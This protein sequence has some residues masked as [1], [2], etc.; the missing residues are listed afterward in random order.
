MSWARF[1]T[2]FM[3]E[4][5]RTLGRPAARVLLVIVLLLAYGLTSGNVMVASGDG[6]VGG[7][8][9]WLTSEFQVAMFLSVFLPV[10]YLFFVSIAAGMAVPE[11]EELNVG[12]LLHATPL[13]VSEYLLGKYLAVVVGFALIILAQVFFMMVCNHLIPHFD[14]A[15]YFGPFSWRNYLRPFCFFTLPSLVGVAGVVFFLGTATR[16]PILVY[17]F[18]VALALGSIF[19]LIGWSPSWLPPRINQLL[20]VLDPSGFRWL[21]ETWFKVDRGVGHYNE[22]AV[23]FDGVFWLNRGLW[24]MVGVGA[25]ALSCRL[26]RRHLRAV[27]VVRGAAAAPAATRTETLPLTP[28]PV[29]PPGFLAGTVAVARFEA[30][31][32]L[33]HPGLY[34]FV[35]LILAQGGVNLWFKQGF[36]DMPVLLTPG[37]IA[38]GMWNLLTVAVALLLLFYTVE[39]FERERTTGLAPLFASTALPT[40]AILCG[41]V[42]ANGIVGVVV[43]I[44]A[45]ALAWVLLLVQGTIPMNILPFALVWGLVLLPTFLVWVAYVLFWQALLRSRYATYAVALATLVLFGYGQFTDKLTWVSNWMLWSS[46]RWSDLGLFELDRG[47]LLLNRLMVLGLALFLV[48]VALRWYPRRERDWTQLAHRFRWQPILWESLKLAPLAALP[49]VLGMVLWYQVETGREGSAVKKAYK[50]YWRQNLNTWKDVPIPALTAVEVNLR[51]EPEQQAFQVA[52]SY[53][54]RNDGKEP[55]RRL[56][57]TVGSHWQDLTWTLNGQAA[58][59]ENFAGLQVFQLNPPLAVGAA[60]RVGFGYHGQYP[61]GASK[62]KMQAGEFILPSGVVLNSF[63]ASF[64]PIVGYVESVGIDEENQYEP[65]QYDDDFHLKELAPLFGSPTPFTLKMTIEGPA[66]YTYN[67]VGVLVSDQTRDGR[68][69]MIWE[70]DHPVRIF[71]VVAGKWTVTRGAGVSLHYHAEHRYNIAEMQHAL[72]SAR[73]YYGTWFGEFP[74]KELKLSQFPNLADYA[75]GFATNVVFVESG[76]LAKD[77]PLGNFAFTVTAHEAAHQWWGNMLTPGKGPGANILSEGLAH[78]STMLLLEQV[79]GPHQRLEFC[80]RLESNYT[81]SRRFDAERPLVKITGDKT[82]DT[83]VTYDKGSWAFWML[84]HHLGRD[85]MLAGLRRFL[86]RYRFNRDHPMLEDALDI[87]EEQAADRAAFRRLARQLFHEVVLPEYRLSEVKKVEGPNG[88][89]VTGKV[90]N[91]GTGTFAV[92]VGVA[93]GPRF[94]PTGTPEPSYRVVQQTVTLEPNQTVPFAVTVP[95]APERVVVDPDLRVLQLFRQQAEHRF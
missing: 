36:L 23:A 16:R 62:N 82:G 8:K 24:L 6:S 94:A 92:E 45:F 69:T 51:L 37:E 25:L 68:R 4:L 21:N 55:L 18:P 11:D 43:L 46:L 73:T 78:F 34:L 14:K 44:L 58:A 89:E 56:P 2:V 32:L 7:R 29:R 38:V 15:E 42:A 76:F 66:E 47:A 70:T 75:Q 33:V 5:R 13:T 48:I 87:L 63:S 77:D 1:A 61:F 52:G 80:K 88:W 90:T 91:N 39:S 57:L 65:R 67:G 79:K 84:D 95:F 35:P 20:M 10:I 53:V 64:M 30:R 40:A 50:D 26:Y 49:G 12:P 85:K 81:R 59:P 54:L 72:E 22:H 41:K 27:T 71:N 17:L 19:F 28:Q 83:T 3:M 60:V 93:N 31:Q 74:W 9:A 86:E